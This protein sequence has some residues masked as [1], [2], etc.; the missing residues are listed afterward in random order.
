[1]Q[2]YTSRVAPIYAK[3]DLSNAQHWDTRTKGALPRAEELSLV[4]TITSTALNRLMVTRLQLDNHVE[5]LRSFRKVRVEAVVGRRDEGIDI[6]EFYYGKFAVR[7]E[8][9]PTSCNATESRLALIFA[10]G[11]GAQL[12]NAGEHSIKTH[13]RDVELLVP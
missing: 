7:A 12:K 5:P 4:G 6:T 10:A 3:H 13:G 9:E 1:M 2:Y 8:N 11:A